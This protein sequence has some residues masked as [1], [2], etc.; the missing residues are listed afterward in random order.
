MKS[1]KG[2]FL[3]IALLFSFGQVFAQP[4]T[5]IKDG[6]VANSSQTPSVNA[7]LELESTGKGF[8]LPRLT[9]K[10][11]D[12][13]SKGSNNLEDGLTIYNV[14]TDCI[15]YWS[16]MN[17]M[18]MSLCGTLP[19]AN[20]KVDSSVCATIGFTG[21][22]RQGQPLDEARDVLSL[23]VDVTT[24][25][26][27][28]I[29]V[30]TDNGY[31]FS[32][33]GTF[34]STGPVAIKLKGFGVPA[35]GYSD[36]I[37]SNV[38]N[39]T[40][41][42]NITLIVNGK[43]ENIC[44]TTKLN[45]IKAPISFSLDCTS[46]KLS[47]EPYL[48]GQTVDQN[49]HYV[50]IDVQ[51]TNK[52][53]YRIQSNQVNGI[54][55]KGTGTLKNTG[56]NTIRLYAEGKPIDDGNYT[57][58]VTT[59]SDGGGNECSFTIPVKGVDY[60]VDLSKSKYLG[61]YVQNTKLTNANKL[62]IEVLV[63]S[64]GTASFKIVATD[65]DLV[66]FTASDV[67]LN[68]RGVGGNNAQKVIL[69]SNNQTLPS[70]DKI[71]LTGGSNSRIINSFEI[72]LK[73]QYAQFTIQCSKVKVNGKMVPDMA[74]NDK[75]TVDVPVKVISAGNYSIK[76]ANINGV[77]F[78]ANGS[79]TADQVGK[80]VTVTLKA[81]GIPIK[82][83]AQTV[84]QIITENND[85]SGSCSFKTEAQFDE[86]NILVIGNESA[87]FGPSTNSSIPAGAILTNP[88]N[89]G[90]NGT[91]KSSKIN[92]YYY[93]DYYR[94]NPKL[95]V[96]PKGSAPKLQKLITDK[97]IDAIFF[98]WQAVVANDKAWYDLIFNFV[99]NERGVLV[100]SNSNDLFSAATLV[101][102]MTGSFYGTGD[103]AGQIYSATSGKINAFRMFNIPSNAIINGPFGNL[104]NKTM[105]IHQNG[106]YYKKTPP[107]MTPIASVDIKSTNMNIILQ[108]NTDAFIMI[109]DGGWMS[110]YFSDQKNR[111]SNNNPLTST[112]SGEAEVTVE[113]GLETLSSNKRVD[114]YN[115]FLYE[116]IMAWTIKWVNENRR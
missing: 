31:Y 66:E 58:T 79:F 84:Y 85:S 77:Q 61:T 24:M 82:V 59:N 57:F 69:N 80:E 63:K 55:F 34:M 76:T 27:Y 49:K 42:D 72:P 106:N 4:N 25:G 51:V 56:K 87:E 99:R 33:S 83:S 16:K 116:N 73:T 15:N 9:N 28:N 53:V 67:I 68:Y 62:E 30:I 11:R 5:K 26:D 32:T 17:D 94:D 96:I 22:L 104:A 64:P 74:A 71:T 1:L 3:I 65:N 7:I 8:L 112:R 36:Q 86:I 21:E 43:R 114:A 45:V 110:G 98:T 92:V 37:N 97:K 78:S 81:D 18:W 40:I 20:I 39:T 108:H 91:V 88:S 89:F 75:I 100:Y 60:E 103:F 10:Q 46:Y 29:D 107:D 19:P 13:I 14:D 70:K 12:D 47:G 102:R 101:N 35:V 93:F 54:S 48:I 95:N 90:P 6:T 50:D 44:S 52:G 2:I 41:G 113:Y 109:G 38:V 115:S 23:T 105:G 111:V